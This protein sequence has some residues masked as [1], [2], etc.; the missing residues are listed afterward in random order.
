M[1][2]RS[3]AFAAA[4]RT[5]YTLAFYCEVLYGGQVITGSL[6]IAGGNVQVDYTAAN[7]RRG[8][9]NVIDPDKTLT[10]VNASD[11]LSPYGHELR[12]YRG[13][14]LGGGVFEYVPVATLRIASTVS[15]NGQI[16]VTG[17]DRSRS[18]SRARFES[19]YVIVS[20]TNYGDA[21]ASLISSR[22]PSVQFRFAYVAAT[23]PLIV[24]DQMADPW[25]SAQKLADAVGCDLYFDPMGVCVLE[26]TANPVSAA[27]VSD[28]S[29]GANSLLLDASSSMTDDPGYNGVV[30]DSE[31][32]GGTAIHSVTYD[33]D[34]TS[35]TYYLGPYGTVPTF[36]RTT[37]IT[38]QAQADNA[39]AAELLRNRGGTEQVKITVL[40]DPCQEAGD[41]VYVKSS[42]ERIDN[43]YIAESFTVPFD[44]KSVMPMTTRKRRSLI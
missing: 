2:P 21:I 7:R 37:F 12:P 16:Q 11:V 38:S 14:S 20:G 8:V 19:P 5:G 6:K 9:I 23:T 24:F 40:P 32:P 34:P 29:E 1:Y 28:Y 44:A 33:T 22:L 36:Q 31:P 17:F 25:T 42:L 39:G 26:P 35:P 18:V 43:N 13:M 27:I 3:A 4:L 15:S 41:L 10:P 30:V